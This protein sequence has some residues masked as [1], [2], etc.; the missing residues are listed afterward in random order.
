M[1]TILKINNLNYYHF[2]DLNVS[3]DNSKLYFIVGGNNSGKTTLFRIMASLIPTNN[4]IVCNNLPL[5]NNYRMDYLKQ[6]GIVEKVNKGSF[7]F[8]QVKDEM[9]YP[10]INLGKDLAY[11]KT[12]I[13]E[14]LNIFELDDL[15]DKKIQEL[16]IIEKQKL[17]IILSLLHKPKVLLMDNVL[18][19]FSKSDRCKIINILKNIMLN[20]NMTIINFTTNIEDIIYS[21]KVIILSDFKIIKETTYHEI[22][23]NDQVFYENGLE[24]PFMFDIVNKLKM[25]NLIHKDYTNMKDLVDD[26]WP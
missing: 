5:D 20:D 9:M 10:L 18:E 24:I 4:V 7:N 19:I 17:L 8:Y 25:Y 12:R 1:G 6:I 22:Y 14:I 11:I 16:D 3:F 13:K 2:H 26:I 15:Y 21:D 23:Q